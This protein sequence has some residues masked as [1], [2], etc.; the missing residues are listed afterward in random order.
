MTG[1]PGPGVY[2][3]RKKSP[4]KYPGSTW[5][6]ENGEISFCVA[7]EYSNR[8]IG[9]IELQDGTLGQRTALDTNIFGRI[10]FGGEEYEFFACNFGFGGSGFSWFLISEEMPTSGDADLLYDEILK[11]YTLVFLKMNFYKNYCTG[12]VVKGS[13]VTNK[14]YEEGTEF[15][16]LRT[17]KE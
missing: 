9:Y 3:E 12:K 15:K 13:H 10:C 7:E 16:F 1:C 11:E 17:D 14:I 2:I 6:T 8:F 4:E 5:S